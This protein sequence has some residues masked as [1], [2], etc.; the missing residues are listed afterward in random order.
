MW[1]T[2][3]YFPYYNP[4]SGVTSSHIVSLRE[5]EVSFKDGFSVQFDAFEAIHTEVSKKYFLK[6]IDSL[7]A[8]SGMHIAEHFC[9]SANEYALA[10]FKP[11]ASSN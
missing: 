4:L 10:L 2:L 3:N 11:K 6:E 5:Q 1:P 8:R 7:A 9:D